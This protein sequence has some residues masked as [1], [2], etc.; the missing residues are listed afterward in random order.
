VLKD[1][2]FQIT[3]VAY[4]LDKG[5]VIGGL[6]GSS[7]L[8]RNTFWEGDHVRYWNKECDIYILQ[9]DIISESEYVSDKARDEK[10][11]YS[12]TTMSSF[13]EAFLANSYALDVIPVDSRFPDRDILTRFYDETKFFLNDNHK[14][15]R[16]FSGYE[17]DKSVFEAN[18]PEEDTD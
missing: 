2:L 1:I 7:N 10:E 15:H 3:K 6:V 5:N 16:N 14:I 11:K 8:S 9:D 12:L 4:K 18:E 17:V 13:Y